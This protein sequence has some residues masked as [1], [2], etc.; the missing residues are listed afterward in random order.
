MPGSWKSSTPPKSSLVAEL[1]RQ[2]RR[3]PCSGTPLLTEWEDGRLRDVHGREWT[4]DERGNLFDPDGLALPEA[5]EGA[6][7]VVIVCR[8]EAVREPAEEQ[9]GGGP[10]EEVVVRGGLE[11][12][13]RRPLRS[14]EGPSLARLAAEGLRRQV[15]LGFFMFEVYGPDGEIEEATEC[16]PLTEDDFASDAVQVVVIR[17]PDE[18]GRYPEPRSDWRERGI[19]PPRGVH[20]S[21]WRERQAEGG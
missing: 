15:S 17:R 9:S 21:Q 20:R 13:E 6:V 19:V 2:L 10:P 1:A 11:M 16:W 7:S 5:Q 8:P 4:R 3:R 14:G 18:N 12:P